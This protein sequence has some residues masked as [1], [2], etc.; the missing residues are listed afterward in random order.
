MQKNRTETIAQIQ[1]CEKELQS[2]RNELTQTEANINAIVTDMQKIE[3]KNS[4]AKVI[5]D[6]VKGGKMK[7]SSKHRVIVY[8][9]LSC[10]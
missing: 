5:Y 7:L 9:Q 4:K 2:L 1:Q 8:F 10:A 3:T 6:K